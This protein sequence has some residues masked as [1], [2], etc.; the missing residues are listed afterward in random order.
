MFRD[1]NFNKSVKSSKANI[2]SKTRQNII[3][4]VFKACIIK[5]NL[6]LNDC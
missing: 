5:A 3:Q 1:F 6:C 4:H 2:L